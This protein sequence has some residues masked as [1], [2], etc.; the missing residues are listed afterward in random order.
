MLPVLQRR[1]DRL[2][3]VRGRFLGVVT[4]ASGAQ[5]EFHPSAGAWSMLGVTEHL[6][7][8]EEKSVLGMQKAVPPSP[9]V[10]PVAHFRMAMVRL[11]LRSNF[12]VRVPTSRVLPTGTV[13]LDELTARWLEARRRLESLVATITEADA[14]RARFLH[15]IGGWVSASE[16]VGFLAAHI[17]H[18]E[19][20][21][22]RIRRSPGF[23]AP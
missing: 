3:R 16:G 19:R 6:V 2:D 17:A 22:R 18:H 23:P 1:L 14:G 7:L 21:L 11:V 5:R 13:P 4:A 20:Q 9:R 10:S 8:A 12:R 15:P